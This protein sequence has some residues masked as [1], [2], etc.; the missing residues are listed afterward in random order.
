MD[1]NELNRAHRDAFQDLEDLAQR[2]QYFLQR[3]IRQ[4]KIKVHSLDHR[5]KGL[6]SLWEKAKR[7]GAENP[8]RDIHDL[9]GL[10]VVCLFE[11]DVPKILTII[12]ESF[13]VL[14]VEDKENK[15]DKRLFD[16]AAIHVIAKM[17]SNSDD[18]RQTTSPQ[19]PF[20]VQVRTIGQDAWASVSHHLAYKQDESLPP[21]CLRDLHA[22]SALFYLADRHFE[23]LK[24]EHSRLLSSRSTPHT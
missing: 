20:E 7:Q 23:F 1:L 21:D 6:D 17:K 9:I 24:G 14:E 2:A 3:E 10:R 16:Y 22:L 15:S 13:D 19:I 18:S 8:L 12:R 5:V 4:K 11:S